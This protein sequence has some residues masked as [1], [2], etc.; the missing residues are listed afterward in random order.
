L[1]NKINNIVGGLPGFRRYFLNV[2]FKD[3]W[4]S[5]HLQL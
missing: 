2:G 5:K 4:I 3:N 1:E